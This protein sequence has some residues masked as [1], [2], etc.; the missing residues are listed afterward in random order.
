MHIITIAELSK[1]MSE[2]YLSESAKLDIANNELH[3]QI[4]NPKTTADLVANIA[5]THPHLEITSAHHIIQAIPATGDL[6]Y[7]HLQENDIVPRQLQGADISI[8]FRHDG[9][10]IYSET[11][12]NFR[13]KYDPKSGAVV[14]YDRSMPSVPDQILPR[15]AKN[16]FLRKIIET[17]V[18]V[19]QI[20]VSHNK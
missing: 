17:Q 9:T 15:Y 3:Q 13:T 6:I 11:G 7:F 12:S 2:T 4:F 20:I 18:R 1:H 14:R 10:I 5:K 8:H 16:E 19:E